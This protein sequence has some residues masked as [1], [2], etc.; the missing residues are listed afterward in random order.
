MRAYLFLICIAVIVT[1]CGR[2]QIPGSPRQAPA[3]SDKIFVDLLKE[4]GEK[5]IVTDSEGV[6]VKGNATRIK[7][8]RYGTTR[9][10]SGYTVETEFRIRLP[11]GREI[12]EYVA[13]VGET[14]EKAQ[15]DTLLNFVLTTFHPVY[16]CFINPNDPHQKI[17]Q[18]VVP[19]GRTREIAM[20]DIMVRSGAVKPALNLEALR[21]GIKASIARLPIS[22]GPHW[23]KIVYG[24]AKSQPLTVSATLDNAEHGD[25]T[26]SIKSLDWPSRQELYIAKEF[27]VVK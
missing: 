12:V 24:Q 1:G 2:I 4:H 8:A 19:G 22:D 11:E 3:P 27:I 15:N 6:G 5:S 18:I 7:A 26:A 9:Q 21:T 17:E 23:I 16:K 20:G 25:L 13:G 14:E 10:K